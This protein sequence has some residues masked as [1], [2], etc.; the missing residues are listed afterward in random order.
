[1]LTSS[2]ERFVSNVADKALALLYS[3]LC[4]CEMKAVFFK[5]CLMNM[6]YWNQHLVQEDK[7]QVLNIHLIV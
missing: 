2:R 6:I 1:M 5:L 4:G 3:L 7:I